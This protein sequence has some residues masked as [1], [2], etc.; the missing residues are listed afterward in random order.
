MNKEEVN[1]MGNYWMLEVH[2]PKGKNR[3]TIGKL[4]DWREF[5]SNWIG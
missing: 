2:T 3:A 1:K 5:P 4:P